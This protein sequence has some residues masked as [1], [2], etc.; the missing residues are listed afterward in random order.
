[1]NILQIAVERDS[2]K[3]D[4]IIK[5]TNMK[6]MQFLENTRTSQKIKIAKSLNDT[7]KNLTADEIESDDVVSYK[8][9]TAIVRRYNLNIV[10]GDFEVSLTASVNKYSFNPYIAKINKVAEGLTDDKGLIFLELD[11]SK[12]VQLRY[13]T[14]MQIL[15]AFSNRKSQQMGCLI[16]F[17]DKDANQKFTL[18]GINN[19]NRFVSYIIE[20]DSDG[21]M[22]I[23]IT[24]KI[25][26]KT[27]NNLSVVSSK[28]NRHQLQFKYSST[29]LPSKVICKDGEEDL[30][31]NNIKGFTGRSDDDKYLNT[32][33]E[34]I[35]YNPDETDIHDTT[36]TTALWKEKLSKTRA[37]ILGP[38]V[39]LTADTIHAL[40][41]VYLFN[42]VYN[43]KTGY[44]LIQV[45]PV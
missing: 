21:K 11:T 27:I 9:N 6:E 5:L 30:V 23:N 45:K 28:F 31:M 35:T 43:E 8:D 36:I 44:R 13:Y 3:D 22:R 29:V 1:M 34:F 42:I 10:D 15:S 33:F 7:K 32:D 4:D 18:Y 37:V 24:E 26:I 12:I 2:I 17:N 39:T 25:P 16:L 20:P 19:N 40:G 38:G 14:N 41:V